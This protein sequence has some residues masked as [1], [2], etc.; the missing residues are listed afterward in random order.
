[1]D[2]SGAR[3]YILDRLKNELKPTLYYHSFEHTLDVEQAALRLISMENL[4]TE[5]AIFIQAAA[6]FHDAGMLVTYD[7]HEEASIDFMRDVL[8]GFSFNEYAVEQIAGLINV[9]KM[10]QKAR[11]LPEKILCDADLD[12][13]GRDDFFISSFRLRLEWQDNGLF[14]CTFKEWIQ[15]QI[16]FLEHHHYFTKSEIRLRQKQKF[17]N[18]SELKELIKE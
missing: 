11:T 15:G 18:I 1:M 4:D 6:L 13:L 5:T 9:T 10:P 12:P 3:N 17:K 14:Q 2:F 7:H 8:P 16:S